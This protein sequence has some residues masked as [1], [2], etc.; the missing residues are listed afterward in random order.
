MIASYVYGPWLGL[1]WD[2]SS[3]Q[4][5]V[6]I[7]ISVHVSTHS[8]QTLPAGQWRACIDPMA[9]SSTAGEFFLGFV[10]EN[11]SP[12]QGKN[13]RYLKPPARF[14]VDDPRILDKI[15]WNFHIFQILR[16]QK[17]QPE[18]NIHWVVYNNHLS[19][20]LVGKCRFMFPSLPQKIHQS[21]LSRED[22]YEF[23][24]VLTPILTRYCFDMVRSKS[25]Y[26]NHLGW[27]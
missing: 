26:C 20:F 9:T 3:G 23:V 25:G 8:L 15:G 17:P 18:G 22:R 6:G 21:Y 12:D 11:F 24:Q 7:W 10:R 16:L 27:C 2:S 19:R 5:T 1:C 4:I 14:C 13:K